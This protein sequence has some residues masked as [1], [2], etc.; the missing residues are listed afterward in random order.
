MSELVDL[1]PSIPMEFRMPDA[2]GVRT[3]PVADDHPLLGELKATL[4][5]L[6]GAAIK[7]VLEALP[8]AFV[9]LMAPSSVVELPGLLSIAVL[10]IPPPRVRHG[11]HPFTK[12]P[13]TVGGGPPTFAFRIA[14]FL[15]QRFREIDD[16]DMIDEIIELRPQARKSKKK[17]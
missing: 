4:P 9:K 17:K 14:S 16:D 15:G 10:E 13:L 3:A 5:E 1:Q 7:A 8:R 11:I 6:N 12:Q 2:T